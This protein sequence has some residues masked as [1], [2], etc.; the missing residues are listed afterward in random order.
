MAA[1]KGVS[2]GAL[3]F[4]DLQ[5][6]DQ[7]SN[8]MLS[9]LKK[10]GPYNHKEYN[11]GSSDNK[12][13]KRNCNRLQG[14][15][16]RENLHDEHGR[17]E[18]APSQRQDGDESV[19][20]R[21]VHQ[22][23]QL[24]R[25]PSVMRCSKR[26][27]L[28]DNRDRMDMCPY[29]KCS[30]REMRE[31]IEDEMSPCW[32]KVTI[33]HGRN[34][35]KTWLVNSIQNECAVNFTPVDF[36][37]SHN[38]ARFF[39]QNSI[40]AFA[41][42][43]VSRKICDNENRKIPIF[44]HRS[45]VPYSVKNQLK[46]EEMQYLKLTLNKRYDA[47]Q[48]ALDLR[49]LRFDPGLVIHN[50]DMILNRRHCMD[51][52]LKII[53]GNFPELLSLNLRGNKLYQL[54]GL[55]DIT[56][57]APKVRILNL[58]KNELKTVF[59]LDKVKELKLE[60]LWLEGNPLC[61]TFPNHTAYVSAI[62]RCFPDLLRLD[63]QEIASSIDINVAPSELVQPCKEMPKDI[64][65]L[66]SL[67]LEF[68]QQYYSIYDHGDRRSLLGAYHEEACFSL[69]IPVKSTDQVPNGLCE[70][71]KNSRDI[72]NAKDPYLRRQL[73]KH[74]NHHI[75]DTLSLLPKTR[76]DL[77]SFSIDMWLYT[78]MMLCFSVSGVFEGES[79]SQDSAFEFTRTFTAVSGD[80]FSLRIVNDHLVV[81][82][83]S[84]RT[85]QSTVSI[86]EDTPSSSSIPILSELQQQ[87]VQS[88]STQSGM[89]FE[90]SQKCLEENGWDYTRAAQN[91]I[92]LQGSIPKEAF[93]QST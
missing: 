18:C 86:P 64:E 5:N 32:F 30:E 36:H 54:D 6:T 15:Y 4:E 35:N 46:P 8:S 69:T 9:T 66:K 91:F 67:V 76:H 17:Y 3:H 39:V 41:L 51:A 88:F 24:R 68:L 92:N 85:P 71:L 34:Y 42:K 82:G 61:D 52:T 26:G 31:E 28:N 77:K 83:I 90:W 78:E 72:M 84:T 89:K 65:V 57:K 73:L 22:E 59:E 16:G 70:Y 60:E 74:P 44:V 13:R 45:S 33:P 40:T 25:N 81:S 7:E 75:V 63:G 12:G 50:I 14:N 2:M 55:C 29:K 43:N 19:A 10:S 27:R 11:A 1:R 58:S 80:S 79:D 37:Y 87:M 21:D 49:N 20:M 62:Q 53:E 48:Q 56:E 38:Q 93:N 47:S 23:Q